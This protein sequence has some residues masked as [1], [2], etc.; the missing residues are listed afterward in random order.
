MTQLSE[1]EL[2]EMI[3]KAKNGLPFMA[4][5][6]DHSMEYQ[7]FRIAFLE[8]YFTKAKFAESED[9]ILSILEPKA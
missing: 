3:L 7:I 8:G 5:Y 9:E 1:Q 6:D 4:K 2:T